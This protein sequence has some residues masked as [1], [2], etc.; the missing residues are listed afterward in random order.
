MYHL[1]DGIVECRLVS[2]QTQGHNRALT[3]KATGSLEAE[4]G[5]VLW[6]MLWT[7]AY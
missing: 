5:G 7:H 4:N 6:I 2:H 3:E 1:M